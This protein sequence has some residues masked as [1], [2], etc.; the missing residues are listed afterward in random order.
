M[1][2]D[3]NILKFTE[4]NYQRAARVVSF[5]K[6]KLMMKDLFVV[7]RRLRRFAPSPLA[8]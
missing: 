6:K 1:V 8:S 3:F 4:I 5:L 2:P 7:Y